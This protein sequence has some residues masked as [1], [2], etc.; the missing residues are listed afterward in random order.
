MATRPKLGPVSDAGEDV[1]ANPAFPTGAAS[2]RHRLL[3]QT[4]GRNDRVPETHPAERIGISE[5][6][7]PESLM[8][9]RRLEIQKPVGRIEHNPPLAAIHGDH[10]RTHE[11]HEGLLLCGCLD[12]QKRACRRLIEVPRDTQESPCGVA[13]RP[14]IDLVAV[15]KVGRGGDGI[16]HRDTELAPVEFSGG[17]E[18]R[19]SLET[20]QHPG[21]MAPGAPEPEHA[22]S[23]ANAP[24]EGGSGR[25]AR[26]KIRR[27]LYRDFSAQSVRPPDPADEE[28]GTER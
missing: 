11:R 25:E 21:A 13:T 16:L 3:D 10:D 6:S 19:N 27:E 18:T 24:V 23:Q 9:D 20:H 8:R 1:V 26:R 14:A 17:L 12:G 5:G 22:S 15:I 28:H 2:P 4:G 7:R